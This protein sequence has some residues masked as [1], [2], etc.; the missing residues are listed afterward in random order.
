MALDDLQQLAITE[1]ESAVKQSEAS[2][3]Q[4]ASTRKAREFAEASLEAQIKQFQAGTTN[5][6]IVLEFERN[7]RTAQSSELKSVATYNKAKA[8][9]AVADG[10]ILERDRINVKVHPN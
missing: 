9:L 3:S 7:V 6:F 4:I 5:S 10:T 2:F 8:K 1:V